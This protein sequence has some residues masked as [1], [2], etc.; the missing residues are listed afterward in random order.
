[1]K[2]QKQFSENNKEEKIKAQ[3]EKKENNKVNDKQ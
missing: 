3:N 2:I 1:M